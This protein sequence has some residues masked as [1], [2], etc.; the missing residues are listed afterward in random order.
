MTVSVVLFT[1]DLRLHDNPSLLAALAS[2][3]EVVPLF[4]LD[5]GIESAGFAAPNR[6]AFLADCLADLDAG[7]RERGGRLVVRSGGVVDQVCRAAAESG[8]AEVHLAAGVSAYAW[9]RE[10]RLRAALEA[11]GRRLRVHDAV[12][13]AVPPGAVTPA[14]SDHF[15]VFTPYFRRWSQE[16]LRSV[17]GAPRVVRVPDGVGSERLPSRKDLTGISAGLARGGETAARTQWS[18][19]RRG[20]L[21]GYAAGHDDL[22][23]DATSRLSPHLH[24]GTLSPSSWCGRLPGRAGPPRRSS[25]SCAGGTSTTRCWPPGRS[26]PTPTTGPGTTAGGPGARSR[27]RS[28]PGGRAVPDIRWSMPPCAS[29]ATRAGCTTGGGC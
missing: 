8:A 23:G 10:D 28:R 14:A 7:L 18:A 2:A 24:F 20:G 15:A 5:A 1:S 9:R 17:R 12:I 27:R 29:C 25:G 6:R 22:S 26:R 16:R 3:D 21:A 13:T 4:V 19:W 11:D